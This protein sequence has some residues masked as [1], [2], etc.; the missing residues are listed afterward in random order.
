MSFRAW[1]QPLWFLLVVT[2]VLHRSVTAQDTAPRAPD[3]QEPVVRVDVDLLTIRFS[4][5]NAQGTF[6]NALPPDAFEVYEDGLPQNVVFFKPPARPEQRAGRLW[7]SFLLDV[8]GSTFA[9]RSEE[10]LAART[11]FDNL[12]QFTQVG[13]FGFTDKLLE[14][15]NFTSDRRTAIRAFEKAGRH[16]GRTAIYP[17]LNTLIGK[18]KSVARAGDR[19]VVILVSDGIDERYNLSAQSVALSRL[20]DVSIYTIRVPSAA[21]LYIGASSEAGKP[22]SQ[23]LSEK[24]KQKKAFARLSRD[25]GGLHFSGFGAILDFDRTLAQITDDVFGNLYTVAFETVD[26]R[27]PKAERDVEIRVLRPGLSASSPFKSLPAQLQA[28]RSF[29]A[30]LFGESTEFEGLE[31]DRAY[32]EIGAQL[33]LLRPKKVAGQLGQPFRLTVSPFT[34]RGDRNGVR[35]QLGVIGQLVDGDGK[36]VVRLREI[37]RVDLSAKEVRRGESVIYTNKLLAP[38][39]NYLFRLAVL[40]IP[41]WKMTAFETPVT[42]VDYQAER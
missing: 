6:A 24:E 16:L 9:T 31:L 13:V 8:S 41:T 27:R 21:Q 18:L 42:I 1:L 30:A 4:V 19:K 32:R 11:F 35:T 29:I 34:L 26:P 23:E 14:F 15:Q 17:S 28:K 12:T 7:L 20:N 33:D 38:Q 3:L 40:E 36:E 2:M 22:S 10:I 5:K 39:G 37:F 25:T